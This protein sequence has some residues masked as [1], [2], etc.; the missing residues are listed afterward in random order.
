MIAWLAA[1]P[2][3]RVVA[4]ALLHFVWQGALLGI[5]LWGALRLAG[6][7]AA[8]A[9]YLLACAAL[10]AAAALPVITAVEL[11]PEAAPPL[12]P[13]PAGPGAGAAAL[14]WH[15]YAAVALVGAWL[16]G[17]L[18]RLGRIGLGL[19]RIRGLLSRC[20]PLREE[21]AGRARRIARDMGLARL[22][23]L[24]ES[25]DIDVPMAVGWLRPA[26]LVPLAAITA[27][28][29]AQ[30]D[31]LLAHEIA[32]VR[33]HDFLV[34]VIQEVVCAALFYHPA[35]HFIAR[36]I[37]D[38]REHAAD[39][40]AAARTA[41]GTLARA[42]FALE[43]N[44]GRLPE[45][46]VGSSGGDLMTRIQRLLKDGSPAERR[47]GLPALA[48]AAA[49]VG[50]AAVGLG[51]CA[52][53]AE[54]GAPITGPGAATQVHI[55]W[56]PPALAPYRALFEGAA[57]RH[58][59]DADVLAIVTMVESAGDPEAES[60][61][62]ALGLMQIMPAT[63]ALIAE[64]R[65]VSGFQPERLRD[66]SVNVDF[67]AWY[68]AQQAST[69]AP[70]E[71]GP[72]QVAL[73]SAA[74]NAGPQAVRAY[75]GGERPLPEET[76]R[77]RDMV[78]RMY[79]ERDQ[80]RSATFDAWRSRVRERAAA[81]A[82]PPVDEARVTASFGP[83]ALPG[84]HTGIDLA[85]KP[86]TPIHAPLD[87]AVVATEEDDRRG[88]V[89]VVRHAG[90][91]ETRYHHLGSVTVKQG[92]HVKQGDAIG[93]VGSTGVSTGPHVHYEVRD[94]G[95]PVDPGRFLPAGR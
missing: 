20:A 57:H 40:E 62:G 8:R 44:R 37:R 41:P 27:L 1:A 55:R 82:V 47:G 71:D 67:G 65:G 4:L 60:P 12:P 92:E 36:S 49:V 77:Y 54:S 86:G 84:G 95:A 24:L 46:T 9:R 19:R 72:A 30:L 11:W 2:L 43:S 87:G 7:R 66:P 6:R 73:A 16:S 88:L 17:A 15:A 32:H 23:R 42:L 45:L 50:A 76:L 68:L 48:A 10:A 89:V 75:L 53:G 61:S 33:R 94:L 59:I 51:S 63:G 56:L 90:G 28:P 91:I 22:P 25:A 64:E 18:W 31:A 70:D 38:A 74:Y 79:E 34:N 52:G 14:P 3:V 29:P 35:V 5:G 93:T 21:V 69:F 78:V 81:R 26:V 80:E 58:G 85:A 13:L 83:D 39:D